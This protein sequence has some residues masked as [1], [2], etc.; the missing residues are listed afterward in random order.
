MKKTVIAILL[1]SLLAGF[2]RIWGLN[3]VPP[4]LFGDEI[5]VGYQSYSLLNTGKD[6][7][8]QTL[9]LYLHSF[10]EWRAPLLM[11]ATIPFVKI[12]GL[13]EWGVRLPSVFFGILSIIFLYLLVKKTV[14]EKMALISALFLAIS[15]WHLQYSRAAFELSLL[16][17][18]FILGIYTFM[19]SLKHHRIL[20]FSAFLFGLTIYT[21]S[22]ANI[23]LPLILFLIIW[24]YREKLVLISKKV[25]FTSG[26]ILLIMLA[27]IGYEIISG[28]A[29]ERF[30]IVSIFSQKEYVD[31]VTIQRN[32][33]DWGIFEKIIHNRPLSW[34]RAI[35]LNYLGVFSPIFLLERGD[36]TFRHS[37]HEMGEIYWV[38]YFLFFIGIFYLLAKGEKKEKLF[39]LGWLFLAPIPSSLT[40]DGATHASRLILAL[41]PILVI[42]AYGGFYL[43]DLIR[44]RIKKFFLVGFISLWLVFGFVSYTHRY[45]DHYPKESW[46]WWQ[47]GYKEAM[48]FMKAKENNYKIIAFNNTYEPSLVRFLFWWGYSPSKFLTEFKSDQPSKNIINNFNGFALENKYYFGSVEKNMDSFLKQDKIIYMVSYRDEVEG[49]EDWEK[50][51][52]RDINILK[53]IYNPYGVPIFYVVTS[54]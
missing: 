33:G 41:P 18:L 50:N 2:L 35:G 44:G 27:P 26:I 49:K 40:Y 22:T 19:L 37:V 29:A 3:Q 8:G 9:P 25:I 30:G 4:E 7:Y 15:P 31:K 20:P 42:S 21:Y 28:H 51:P 32:E 38:Q 47:V 6:Y 36:I 39:W 24:I 10:S 5:D 54:K 46:R 16:L 12:F 43:Y 11:Y 23:F 52:P 53:T 34:I 1:I 45:F 17:F 14:N 48:Q 13:N